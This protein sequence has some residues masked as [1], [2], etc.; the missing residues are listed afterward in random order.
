MDGE[1]RGLSVVHW[2]LQPSENE[3]LGGKRES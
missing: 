1:K 3:R 2:I